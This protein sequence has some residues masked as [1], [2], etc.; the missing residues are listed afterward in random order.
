MSGVRDGLKIF[1]LGVFGCEFASAVH[2]GY[3]VVA[4]LSLV[5]KKTERV[6]R[7]T[8]PFSGLCRWLLV[9]HYFSLWLRRLLINYRLYFL[10]LKS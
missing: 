3:E 4:G 8:V 7:P 1:N 10:L 6:T 5:S 9:A 2:D